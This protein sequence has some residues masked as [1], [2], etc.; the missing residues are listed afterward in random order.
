MKS[1]FEELGGTYTLGKDGM[2]YPNLTIDDNDQRP[3]GK[4]GRM[5]RTYLDGKLC[6]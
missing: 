1:L 4:W 5:H 2:Y 6:R 3:I